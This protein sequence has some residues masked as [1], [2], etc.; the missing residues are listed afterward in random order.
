MADAV[1]G[2]ERLHIDGEIFEDRGASSRTSWRDALGARRCR[3]ERLQQLT[4]G[5]TLNKLWKVIVHSGDL[6]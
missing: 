4:F 6:I 2:H 1:V 3:A 5:G